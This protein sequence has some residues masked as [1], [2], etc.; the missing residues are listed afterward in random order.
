MGMERIFARERRV[1]RFIHLSTVRSRFVRRH[2]H[3]AGPRRQ[4]QSSAARSSD[5]HA[6]WC[7]Q[8]GRRHPL[9]SV[10]VRRCRPT[11]R[12]PIPRR[13]MHMGRGVFDGGTT[14]QISQ[15][16]GSI[17]CLKGKTGDQVDLDRPFVKGRKVLA[18]GVLRCLARALQSVLLALFHSSIA[19]KQARFAESGSQR[20][21]V[22]N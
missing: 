2:V 12:V 13:L 1:N 15:I 16:V 9:P 22:L 4:P 18:L 7:D 17:T 19:C 8:A 20:L 11:T 6:A 10:G 5:D 14:L 21:I 3:V